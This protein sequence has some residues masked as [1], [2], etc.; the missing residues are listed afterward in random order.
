MANSKVSSFLDLFFG[1]LNGSLY[2]EPTRLQYQ[3][4]NKIRLIQQNK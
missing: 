3:G 1:T 4:K 2:V